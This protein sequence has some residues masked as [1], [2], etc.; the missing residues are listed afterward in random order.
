MWPNPNETADLV[1]FAEEVLMENFI[2]FAV[3][4]S[5]WN[6]K[7]KNGNTCWP[8]KLYFLVSSTFPFYA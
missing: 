7:Q 3:K 8:W 5:Y 6:E 4:V 1:T 2:F